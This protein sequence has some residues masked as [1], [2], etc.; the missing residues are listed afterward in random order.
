MMEVHLFS[1][2]ATLSAQ[3]RDRTRIC[4]VRRSTRQVMLSTAYIVMSLLKT[5][6]AFN[7]LEVEPG[8]ILKLCHSLIF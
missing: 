7:A 8:C 2:I 6:M 1:V 5:D 4:Y 3:S